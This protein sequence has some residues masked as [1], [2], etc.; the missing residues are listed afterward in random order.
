MAATRGFGGRLLWVNETTEG[1]TPTDPV[2]KKVSDHV[3]SVELSMDPKNEV[4]H[5]IGSYDP[6]SFVAGLPEY[7]LKFTYLL[8][9]N[10]KDT[11]DEAINRQANNTLKSKSFEVSAGLDDSTVGYYTVKGAKPD[12]VTTKF[13]VGKPVEVTE[14][15]KALSVTRATSAPSIGTGSRESAALGALCVGATSSIERGGADVALITRMAEF[16]VSHSLTIEGTDNQTNPKA[17]FE[18]KRECKGSCDISVD[19]GGVALA[20]AVMNGTEASVVF[21]F[22]STGAPQYTFTTT[23]WDNFVLPLNA[24]EAYIKR[25]CPWTALSATTGTVA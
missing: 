11:L 10:R 15:Y 2:Y 3:Q 5:D 12:S 18:G 22:G 19:D 21:K 7:G 20:D 24:G 9:T 6:A 14:T 17:I 16:T 23:R 1:T 25:A 8:H 4:Y 13:E